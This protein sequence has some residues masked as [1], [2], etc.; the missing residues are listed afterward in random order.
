MSSSTPL[1]ELLWQTRADTLLLGILSGLT[2]MAARRAPGEP[3]GGVAFPR[4]TLL[5]IVAVVLTGAAM[6]EL[7][8]LVIGYPASASIGQLVL[9]RAGVLITAAL[10]NAVL[11]GTAVRLAR[12]RAELR[13]HT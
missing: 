5:S 7:S 9:A 2:Y 4:V 10:V 1:L 8:P 12:L 13:A 11:I 6:A 3:H